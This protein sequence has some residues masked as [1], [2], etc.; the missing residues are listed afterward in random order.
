[1]MDRAKQD[2]LPQCQVAGQ[3]ERPSMPS[4]SFI[5]TLTVDMLKASSVVCFIRGISKT[6]LSQLV[7]KCA[8]IFVC[9]TSGHFCLE[10]LHIMVVGASDVNN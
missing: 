8:N 5:E 6:G 9:Y 2:Q 1:M 10:A 7:V 4:S 3:D